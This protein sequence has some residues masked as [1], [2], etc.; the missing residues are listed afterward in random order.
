MGDS[1]SLADLLQRAETEPGF[2]HDLERAC[3]AL[4]HLVDPARE[5]ESWSTLLREVF[6]TGP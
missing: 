6:R 1:G 5:E 4:T 2:Y 3:E